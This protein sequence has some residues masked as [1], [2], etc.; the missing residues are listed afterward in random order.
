MPNVPHALRRFHPWPLT[1][2]GH[3]QTL[4]GR[5]VRSGLAWQLPTED[6][7]LPAPGG[8]RLLLR[9]TWQ[10]GSREASPSLLLVHG[11]GGDDA[12]AYMVST[13]RLAYSRGW[14]VLRMNMRGAGDGGSVTHHLYNA[15][16]TGDLLAALDFV[17]ASSKAVAVAGFSLGASLTLLT[18]GRER[19]HVPQAVRAAV[20]VAVPADLAECAVRLEEGLNTLYSVHFLRELRRVWRDRARRFPELYPPGRERAPRTLRA[21]DDAITAP[22]GG[23]DGAD[24]YYARSSAGPWLS[25]IDRPTLVLNAA[26]DPIVPPSTVTRWALPEDGSVRVEVSPTGGHVGFLGPSCAPGHFWAA[27]RVMAFVEDTVKGMGPPCDQICS[28]RPS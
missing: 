2:G 27:D 8:A 15:G 25:S 19:S 21:W 7:V 23:Y 16:L 14:H 24:D 13:G 17:A 9:A 1:R 4:I 11:L 12:S 28:R 5:L 20:A 18:L 3:R 10:P 26:D 22:L 6:V